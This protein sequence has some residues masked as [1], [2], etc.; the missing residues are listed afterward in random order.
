MAP[1]SAAL[2]LIAAGH[3]VVGKSPF[4]DLATVQALMVKLQFEDTPH[5]DQYCGK[6]TL[7][8]EMVLPPVDRVS[9]VRV[10]GP[11][12]ALR[13]IENLRNAIL[14]APRS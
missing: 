10:T 14:R 3:G 6:M 13:R 11:D 1:L 8:V 5:I 4:R 12:C 9:E 2:L 7:E